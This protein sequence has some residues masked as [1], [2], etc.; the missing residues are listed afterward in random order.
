MHGFTDVDRQSDP[1]SWVGV[2]DRLADEPFYQAYQHRVRELLHLA[3]GRRYVEVGAGTGASAVHLRDEH[4]ADVV[5]VDRAVTMAAAMQARGLTRCAVADAH[6][7]PFLDD[8]FDGAWS[9][10]TVQHLADPHAAI[11]ELVRVVRPGGRIVLADP[12]YDTQV[13]DIADQ[14]LAR[15]VL[16]F[17]ADVLLRNGTLAHQHAGI[18]A[19]LGLAD[20][21]VEPRTL[22][23]R[24]PAA[25]D[26]VLGLRSWAATA[27]QRGVLE[28]AEARAFEDRFDEAV[29]AGRFTYA[30]TFFLTAATVT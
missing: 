23:V 16:R 11:G 15:R 28:P 14:D 4:D 5:T 20:I 19:T 24:D 8:S 9:D 3:P 1:D 29:E 13:L 6:R 21:T 7:L 27:A 30:V 22:L 12:D 18:L 26:N 2:L 25:A 10:R 17:R